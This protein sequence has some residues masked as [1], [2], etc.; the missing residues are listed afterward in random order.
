MV[1]CVYCKKLLNGFEFELEFGP[2]SDSN[3][4]TDNYYLDQATK[5]A[6]QIQGAVRAPLMVIEN[7]CQRYLD[8]QITLHIFDIKGGI[9]N[10]RLVLFYAEE[11]SRP[12]V[13]ITELKHVILSFNIIHA[14]V[15]FDFR[16]PQFV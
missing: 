12:S 6:A 11:A 5:L 7:S 4:K 16:S 15:N 1:F 8:L 9:D 3:S 13:R 10:I 14:D 2:S